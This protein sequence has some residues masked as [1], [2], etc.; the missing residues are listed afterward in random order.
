MTDALS[1]YVQIRKIL[2]WLLFSINPTM[3]KNLFGFL[4][5]IEPECRKSSKNS[6]KL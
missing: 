4:K 5:W 2:Q 1:R 6:K 3:I